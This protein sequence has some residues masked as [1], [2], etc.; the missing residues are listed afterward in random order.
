MRCAFAVLKKWRLMRA[1]T[2]AL[3]VA[4]RRLSAMV[5]NVDLFATVLP[6]LYP[7]NY[8]VFMWHRLC[9]TYGYRFCISL[10]S[11]LL[12]VLRFL[13]VIPYALQS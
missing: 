7:V 12:N 8:C 10:F 2:S 13:V 11:G 3:N 1:E 4:M 9:I 5:A 6:D